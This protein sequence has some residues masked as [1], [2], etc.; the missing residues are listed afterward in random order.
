[1]QALIFK[2][3][4]IVVQVAPNAFEVTSDFVWEDC[5]E[6][7]QAYQYEYSGNE[8]KKLPAQP[9][10]PKAIQNVAEECL[11]KTDWVNQPD[12]YD[13]LLTPHLLNRDEFLAYRS[14]VRGYLVTPPTQN[15]VWPD[16]PQPIWS[17]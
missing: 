16:E 5:P 14:T 3:T 12:V 9:I 15:F 8:F 7:V 2:S 17:A 4:G 13:P 10:N 1:M 6:Y 11:A